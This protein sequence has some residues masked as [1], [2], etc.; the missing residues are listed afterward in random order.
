MLDFDHIPV[1]DGH[2]ADDY[3]SDE[4]EAYTLRA[5]VEGEEVGTLDY[6]L[7]DDR[8]VHVRWVEVSPELRRQGI[9][10]ALFEE[11]LRLHPGCAFQT[12]GLTDDGDELWA[13]L[14]ERGFDVAY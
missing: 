11:A 2:G 7:L 6:N 3:E 4:G 10:I 9:A 8:L 12:G 14:D 5:S 13:A 1:P